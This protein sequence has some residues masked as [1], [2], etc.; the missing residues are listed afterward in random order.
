[1]KRR[2]GWSIIYRQ[3]KRLIYIRGAIMADAISIG[4]LVS[5]GLGFMGDRA[6]AKAAKKASKYNQQMSMLNKGLTEQQGEQAVKRTDLEVRRQLGSQMA[7]QGASGGGFS[8]SA[9]DTLRDSIQEGEYEKLATK[10]GYDIEALNYG[11]E[12]TREKM[13]RGNLRGKAGRGAVM[14]LL[15]QGVKWDN[16]F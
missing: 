10:Q 8:G 9:L 7:A 14:G 4:G 3:G 13:Q 15:S 11:S 5:T 16:V 2:T 12:A 1:V 6:D